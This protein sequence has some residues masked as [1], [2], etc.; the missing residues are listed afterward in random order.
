MYVSIYV[1]ALG[2]YECCKY[3]YNICI[4]YFIGTHIEG[5]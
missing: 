4:F 1:C 2:I 3:L 5:E